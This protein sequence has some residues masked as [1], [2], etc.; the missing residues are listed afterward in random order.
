M[1][2]VLIIAYIFPPIGGSGVQRTV[3]FVKYLPEFGWQPLVVCGDDGE[4]FKDGYDPSLLKEI[5]PE[6]KVWRTDFISPLSL[7]H[8]IHRSLR[9]GSGEET[10]RQA[11]ADKLKV[12]GSGES[13]S[14]SNVRKLFRI[15]SKPLSPIEFPPIDAALYWAISVLPLCLKIIKKEKVE[16]IYTT[17]FP[18]SDHVTGYLLKRLTGRPWVADFR[19]PWTKNASA[20]NTGWRG[21]C[22]AWIE[23]G[24]LN[25]ADRIIS[26]TPTYTLEF[27]KISPRKQ[28]SRFITIENGYD[29]IDFA[30]AKADTTYIT[31]NG[32]ILIS[33]V[34]MIYDGTALPFFKAVQRLSKEYQSRLSVRFVGGLPPTE[35]K[36][37]DEN[38]LACLL[39]LNGRL[40]HNQAV[41]E[42][43]NADI[44]LLPIGCGTR[45]EGH[46]PG[47]LFEY[48]KSG[49]PILLIGP[50]GD[51]AR[52]VSE[53]CTGYF[54][55]ADNTEEI[56]KFLFALAKS[57]RQSID[58][59]YHPRQEIITR[60]ERRYLTSRLADVLSELAPENI[61]S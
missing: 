30:P 3:K 33:H 14:I 18:Y 61:P 7:R 23:K 24:I 50:E 16:V 11:P 21:K 6:T 55:D 31:K 26:V 42:M 56:A 48:M 32:K 13:G 36:W 39:E 38:P 41:D 52:L 60:Y 46:Y 22:D 15:L 59:F 27:Q 49:T 51:A 53:S 5:P 47:K 19:D 8:W 28:D 54:I 9:H 58:R 44:V 40:P 25:Y 12:Q 37:V 17:S 1:K 2:K 35:Q 34:G 4:V 45:W 20:G 10:G 57:S 43:R 29:D